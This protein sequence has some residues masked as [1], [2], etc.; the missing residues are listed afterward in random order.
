MSPEIVALLN[1]RAETLP[2][3]SYEV[4][5]W[6]LGIMT[7]ELLTGTPPFGLYNEDIYE[8]IMAGLSEVSFAEVSPVAGD[9]IEKLLS[10]DPGV[11]LG[12]N[13]VS[14]VLAHPFLSAQLGE[15]V[16]NDLQVLHI[17]TWCEFLEDDAVPIEDDP[18]LNF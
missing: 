5:W 7:Y 13:G 15:A 16:L 1:S 6:A 17:R 8:R 11:R 2:G 4:D 18:F 3:Y 9:F 14:E 10:P 12:H